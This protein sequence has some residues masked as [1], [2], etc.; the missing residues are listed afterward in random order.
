MKIYGIPNC[1]TVKKARAWLES[2]GLE[3]E[4]HDYKK[5]G[6]PEPLMQHL[7][8]SH[9]HETL[10]NRKGPT[11]RNLPDEIKASVRDAH[12][13][14]DIMK[15]HSSVIKRPIIERDGAYL[16]GFDEAAY[17]AFFRS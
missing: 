9:G 16:I 17:A 14:L 6:V 1:N 5:Q 12:S 11:W 10:I 7:L 13:A 4:F 3:Y 15:S 2:Q 8:S